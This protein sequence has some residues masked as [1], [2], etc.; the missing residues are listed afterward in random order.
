MLPRIHRVGWRQPDGVLPREDRLRVERVLAGARVF[1]AAITALI[2][3][4]NPDDP[5]LFETSAYG[6]LLIYAIVAAVALAAVKW[7]PAH[8]LRWRAALHAIDVVVAAIV[9]VLARGP[10]SP[11]FIFF[12]FVL[13]AA[14]MRWGPGPT[15]ATGVAAT[16]LFLIEGVAASRLSQ[17]ELEVTRFFMRAAYLLAGTLILAQLASA[18]GT[19]HTESELLSGLLARVKRGDSFAGTLRDVLHDCLLHTHASHALLVLKDEDTGR[20]YTWRLKVSAPASEAPPVLSELSAADLAL[21]N[22]VMPSGASIWATGASRGDSMRLRAIGDGDTLSST[23]V[24]AEPQQR[25]LAAESAHAYTAVRLQVAAWDACLLLFDAASADE[26]SLRFLHRLAVHVAPALHGQYLMARER[27]H[28]GDVERAHL[29]RE[30]HDGLIQSLIGLE[31]QLDALRR[32]AAA[33]PL[34]AELQTMQA[35]LHD[36]ILDTRDLMAHLKTPR[37][38]RSG[39]IDELLALVERFRHDTGI[40]TQL[41]CSIDEIDCSPRTAQ[42]LARIVQEALVNVRK[43]AAA[44]HVVVRL[45]RDAERWTLSIDDD[46]RGFAFSGRLS[47]DDLDRQRRGPVVIKERVRAIGGELSVESEPGRGSRLSIVWPIGRRSRTA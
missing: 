44:R 34:A 31:M 41:V 21:L 39:L 37:I 22:T 40:D 9:T 30:L 47:Q 15:V 10:G 11:F 26:S 28:I 46:G 19:F 13:L 36:S 35:R 17:G 14:A 29:A 25:L 1:L 8:V 2:V 43:H 18:I 6:V 4:L 7:Q 24:S 5:A 20:G 16:T 42:E 38:G 3:S 23:T 33:A 27:A 12:V 45:G 32:R